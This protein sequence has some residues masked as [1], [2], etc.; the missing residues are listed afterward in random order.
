MQFNIIFEE[1]SDEQIVIN[2][3]ASAFLVVGKEYN[4]LPAVEASAIPMVE[5][6]LNGLPYLSFEKGEYVGFDQNRLFFEGYP[7]GA[8]TNDP[9]WKFKFPI[10][11][12]AGSTI[13]EA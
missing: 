9:N 12:E 8:P 3:I 11:N 5:H 1:I 6:S 13:V 4:F 7:V 10:N 2:L